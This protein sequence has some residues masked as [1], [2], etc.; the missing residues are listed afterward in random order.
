MRVDR[1]RTKPFNQ[2]TL[3]LWHIRNHRRHATLPWAPLVH[4]SICFIDC[5][6]A[7][8]AN[9]RPLS[10]SSTSRSRVTNGANKP[11]PIRILASLV[12]IA[13]W[14]ICVRGTAISL[15]FLI[16]VSNRSDASPRALF[17]FS[18]YFCG[19]HFWSQWWKFFESLPDTPVDYTTGRTKVTR[20]ANCIV[21]SSGIRLY[22][23]EVKPLVYKSL[24]RR[25]NGKYVNRT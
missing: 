5:V 16:N 17:V 12:I 11:N 22:R 6:Q 7:P 13:N 8:S 23:S 21:R 2:S 14:D 25:I 24:L 9:P 3:R 20:D 18:E 15:W 1:S 10:K 19:M 4:A